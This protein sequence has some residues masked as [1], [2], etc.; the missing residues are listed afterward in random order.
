MAKNIAVRIFSE[1]GDEL[2]KAPVVLPISTSIEQLQ[3]LC[4]KLLE[5]EESIPISF[6]TEEGKDINESLG[7]SL[8][9]SDSSIFEKV[10]NFDPVN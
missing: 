4:N 2:T 6:R 9:N 3:S 8:A 7:Q 10:S 5:Y 1:T